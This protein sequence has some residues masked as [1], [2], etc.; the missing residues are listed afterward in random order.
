V[1]RTERKKGVCGQERNCGGGATAKRKI[2]TAIMFH[3]HAER[4]KL[5]PSG[6]RGK[7]DLIGERG[8]SKKRTT[9][10]VFGGVWRIEGSPI[11]RQ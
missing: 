1:F 4:E 2:K 9:E 5:D 10:E 11:C 8:I 7:G 3:F 6:I